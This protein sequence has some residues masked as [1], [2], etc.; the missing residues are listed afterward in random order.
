MNIQDDRG[1]NQVCRD[2]KA[3]RVRAERRFDMMLG[4]MELTRKVSILEIGCGLG[5]NVF[6]MATKSGMDVMTFSKGYAE[7]LLR[8]AG[9]VDGRVD[10]KAFLRPGIPDFFTQPSIA[11]GAVLE[12]IPLLRA[13]AQSILI[14]ASVRS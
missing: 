12:R 10:F 13:M 1:F 6:L 7:R 8:N 11:T 5:S 9:F 2:L 14:Q 4:A 3:T